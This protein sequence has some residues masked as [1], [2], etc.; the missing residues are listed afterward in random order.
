MCIKY[1]LQQLQD[2][3]GWNIRRK[4]S[5][6]QTARKN[7]TP[8]ITSTAMPGRRI[9][10]H[11]LVPHPYLTNK[12]SNNSIKINQE[13]DLAR[14]RKAVT[15][16][17]A[18]KEEHFSEEKLKSEI[19]IELVEKPVKPVS[20]GQVNPASGVDAFIAIMVHASKCK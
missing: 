5:L 4:S 6:N 20:A 17:S 1:P 10:P 9:I 8:K 18:V 13:L 15:E 16:I 14:I 19:K 2:D 7:E 3:S 12:N 11:Q